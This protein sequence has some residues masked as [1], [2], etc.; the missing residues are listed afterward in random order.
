MHKLLALQLRKAFGSVDAVPDNLRAFLG[1]VETA[2]EQADAERAMLE[3]TM[4]NV[5]VEL[6]D[7]YHRLRNALDEKDGVSQA[8][9]VLSATL[10]S[11]ADGIMVVDLGGRIIRANRRFAALLQVPD[12]VLA[13]RHESELLA[14][15]APRVEDPAALVAAA[16]GATHEPAKGTADVVRFIDGR[17]FERYSLPQRI[18]DETIGRVWTW[19]DVTEQRSLTAQLQQAQKME[20]IGVLASGIAQAWPVIFLTGHADV[21]TAVDSVKRGA[22]DFCEKPFSDNA[23]VD[24]IKPLARATARPTAARSSPWI[25][26]PARSGR[27][28]RT[29]GSIRR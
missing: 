7:R 9:S 23:L 19:R 8:L 27:W 25:R 26:A 12:D 11:T 1:A 28:P 2:Y 15:L 5:S 4:E 3:R 29:R 17:V 14:F 18:G 13:L 22:Y 16:R 20:A 6:A 24:R 10:E 21:P